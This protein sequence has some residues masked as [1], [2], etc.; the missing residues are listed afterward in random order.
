MQN[1]LLDFPDN[2]NMLLAYLMITNVKGK[3]GNI[4]ILILPAF[5]SSELIL[6]SSDLSLIII[7]RCPFNTIS[8]SSCNAA[9][10]RLRVS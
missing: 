6:S 8:P 9:S 1:N 10:L 3:H 4:R 2:P 7:F 5:Y